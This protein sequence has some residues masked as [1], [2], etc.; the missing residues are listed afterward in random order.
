M[1]A[2]Q[3]EAKAAIANLLPQ[4]TTSRHHMLLPPAPMQLQILRL[5]RSPRLAFLGLAP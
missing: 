4:L 1:V 2:G 5:V 3:L